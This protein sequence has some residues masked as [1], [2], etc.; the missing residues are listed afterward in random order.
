MVFFVK[1]RQIALK[2]RK[3]LIADGLGTKIL[4]E[5]YSWHFAATWSHMR[6]LVAAH[7]GDL[8]RAFPQSMKWISRAVSLPISVNMAKEVPSRI[9]H[10]LKKAMQA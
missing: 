7:G 10:A 1:N 6:A 8:E 3:Q 9:L 2:C 4:P 5:A